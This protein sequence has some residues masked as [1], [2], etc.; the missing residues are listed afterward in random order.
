MQDSDA[1]EV[2]QPHY[3]KSPKPQVFGAVF[4]PDKTLDVETSRARRF[5]GLRATAPD[6][7]ALY[8]LAAQA[9]SGCERVLDVGCGSGVGTAVLSQHFGA[10]TALDRDLGAVAFARSYLR[11]VNVLHDAGGAALAGLPMHDGACLIDVLGHG[12]DPLALLRQ[13]R[14]LLDEKGRVFIAE[15]RAYSAQALLPPA[16]RAFSVAGLSELMSRAGFA[17]EVWFDQAGHFVACVARS[18]E[19]DAWR[20]LE[21]ADLARAARRWEEALRAYAS[22]AESSRPELRL[23]GLLGSAKVHVG[24]GQWNTACQCWLDAAAISPDNI[25]ALVGLAEMSLLSGEHNQS[26]ELASRALQQDAC[27]LGAVRILAR[28]AGSMEQ[29][30]AFATWQIANAL[31]P[32][33]FETAIELARLAA[34]RGELPYAIWVLERLRDFR[35]DLASEFHVT[36][37]WLYLTAERAGD[38]RLEAQLARAKDPASGSVLELWAHLNLLS[39]AA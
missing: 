2:I 1:A 9:L 20:T 39:S 19:D 13:V 5:P 21:R 32:T 28:T 7:R 30:D 27:D 29:Q 23:W 17:P 25:R 14:R 11:K 16:V 3:T 10:V 24:R 35:S 8:N 37:S 12:P 18:V 38:A 4:G 36:L 6:T 31:A 33:D 22:L 15:P 34:G 26:L